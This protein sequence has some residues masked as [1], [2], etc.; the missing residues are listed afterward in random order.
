MEFRIE[1]EGPDF[2]TLVVTPGQDDR[3]A[4]HGYAT[5]GEVHIEFALYNYEARALIEL[6]QPIADKEDQ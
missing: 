1:D 6:L 5:R 3:F 2:G 4:V